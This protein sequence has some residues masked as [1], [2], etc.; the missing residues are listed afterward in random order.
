[1]GKLGAACV[2]TC[3][4]ALGVL[5]T[6]LT[7]WL[8]GRTLL[9]GEPS[10]FVLEMPP[11]RRPQIGKVIVRSV[12]DRTI[13]VLGRAI[14]TAAPVSL[15]IWCMANI[16]LHDASL[17]QS[18]AG[19]LS[20]IGML[21]GVDGTILLGFMLGLPANEIVL[22]VV[23]TAYLG[24]SRLTDFGSADAL[25]TLLT[26]NGWTLCT[27]ACFLILT[28]FHSPCATTLLTIRKETD[29][30]KWT[31]AAFLLPTVIGILLCIL[32][33]SLYILL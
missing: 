12:L 3:L 13:F 22:P 29:S 17:L 31:L 27:A 25:C 30:R 5:F 4:V 7:S 16:R 28:L 15:L 26:A 18:A 33:R 32:L 9:N 23:V 10:S 8:L 1:M 11:Y 21:L 14:M 2:L 24:A 20:P 19:L 6:M